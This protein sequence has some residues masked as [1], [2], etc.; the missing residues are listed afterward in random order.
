MQTHMDGSSAEN[1]FPVGDGWGERGY[2]SQWG[3]VSPVLGQKRSDLNA[4]CGTSSPFQGRGLLNKKH[5]HTH[6]QKY[7]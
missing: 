6:T 2:K 4:P 7:L 3:T 5:T 1:Y